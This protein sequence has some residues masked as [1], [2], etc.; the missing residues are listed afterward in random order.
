[1]A[2]CIPLRVI[3]PK[4][5]KYVKDYDSNSFDTFVRTGVANLRNDLK[6]GI[7]LRDSKW[8][9]YSSYIFTTQI[10]HFSSCDDFYVDV[11]CGRCVNCLRSR[12]TMWRIRL[13]NEYYYMSSCARD[14]SYFV[15]LTIAPEYYEAILNDTAKYV[16]RFLDRVRK[17][18]GTSPRHFIVTEFGDVT[19]RYHLHGIFFDYPADINNLDLHWKYGFVKIRQLT[20]R[21]CN[22]ITSYITKHNTDMVIEPKY[23]EKLFVSPGLGKAY[24]DDAYNQLWHRR[25]GEPI[26]IMLNDSGMMQLM[27]KYFRQ[28]IFTPEELD[29][30]KI[31]FFAN[32]HESVI[33]DPPYRIGKRTY[34]DYTL[35]L[36]DCE[37]LR[38]SYNLLY[39]RKHFK[40]KS[41]NKE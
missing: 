39:P 6:S 14:N 18:C 26:P 17:A 11:P 28:K 8:N 38:K 33:P 22:Y 2:C 27:P 34:D 21:R 3:N 20:E 5:K 1:M 16:R 15:T 41:F 24:C 36:R 12:Q 19:D 13:L 10:E 9:A 23:V 29:D 25:N 30:L 35:Y 7:S 37:Q 31:A 4:Y 40:N 32:S